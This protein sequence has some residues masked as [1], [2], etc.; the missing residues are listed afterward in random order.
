MDRQ[1]IKNVERFYCG[2]L[3]VQSA[4]EFLYYLSAEHSIS[5]SFTQ[6]LIKNKM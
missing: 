1:A 3:G 5:T 6:S 2:S 4:L